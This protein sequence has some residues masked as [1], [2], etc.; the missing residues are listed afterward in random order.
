MQKHT[1]QVLDQK[2]LPVGA[3][4]LV[5]N[6]LLLTCAHVVKAAGSEPGQAISLRT[7]N[8]TKLSAMVETSRDEN[9]EDIASLR[10]AAPLDKMKP[11]PLVPQ[12]SKVVG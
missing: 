3:A 7:P 2:N 8:G 11:L 5:G 1:I 9:A 10:L 4:F 6:D 12:L